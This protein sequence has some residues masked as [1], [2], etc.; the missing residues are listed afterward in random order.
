MRGSDHER[1]GSVSSFGFGGSNFHIALSEYTGPGSRAPRLRTT[2]VEL[3]VLGG[4]DPADLI[5]Q[6]RHHADAATLDGYLSFLAQT[7]QRAYAADSPARLAFTASDEADL[8]AKLVQAVEW[9]ASDPA[10]RSRSS[11]VDP[12][13]HP[14]RNGPRRGRCRVRLSGPGQ[15]VPVHGCGSRDELHRGHRC[16]G[17]CRRSGLGRRRAPR[18]GLPDHVVRR[19]CR[20]RQ[21]VVAHGDPL[22]AAGDRHDQPRMLRVLDAIGLRAQHVAGHSFGEITALHAAGTLSEADM[23]RVARQRGMLMAEAAQTPGSM[24]AVTGSIDAVRDIVERSGADVVIA[25]HNSPRQVVLSGPTDAIEHDRG[26]AARSRDRRQAAAGRHRVPLIGRQRSERCVRRVPRRRH[27]HG[28]RRCRS[29]PTR[30]RR[31]YPGDDVDEMRAQLARQLSHPVRFVEMIESMYASG[32][33]T[34][35]EVGPSSVLTGLI[36]SILD[37]RDHLAVPLDKKRARRPLG[38]VRRARP[39]RRGRDR[40]APRRTVAR[41]RRHARTRTTLDSRSWRSRSADPTTTVPIH[42]KI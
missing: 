29:I 25:N 17:S 2:D 5:R 1:R 38:A 14:L 11:D 37:G 32:A 36:G 35:V 24:T 10:I 42:P 27:V 15:P 34:F 30:P 16:L 3:V 39:T 41:V 4:S 19:G 18:R 23:I 40:H 13:R 9:I 12:E 33:R 7:S 22:G 21:R 26:R 20:R 28:A 6:A 8:R 31:P